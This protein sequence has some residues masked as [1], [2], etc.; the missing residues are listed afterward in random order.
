MAP[1]EVPVRPAGANRRGCAVEILIVLG[2]TALLIAIAL[3]SLNRMRES[4]G[5]VP[6]ASNLRR[7]GQALHM[8]AQNSGGAFPQTVEPLLADLAPE[9]FVCP[10]TDDRPARGRTPEEVRA[11]LALAGHL[12]YVYVGAGVTTRMGSDVVIAYDR[13][14]NHAPDGANVLFADGHIDWVPAAPFAQ[15]LDEV[16]AG[17]LPVRMPIKPAGPPTSAPAMTR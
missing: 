12:S 4:G 14:G 9:T 11:Q 16:A 13:P 17:R 5:N 2:L 7:I 8:Y 10:S 3:P 15:L 1:R 6:C